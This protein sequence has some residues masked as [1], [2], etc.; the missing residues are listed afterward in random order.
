VLREIKTIKYSAECAERN[1]VVV[2]YNAMKKCQETL[3]VNAA[4]RMNEADS[5]RFQIFF[6][7]KDLAL[8]L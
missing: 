7:T 2:E 6:A 8:H 3:S 4:A 1:F 5:I